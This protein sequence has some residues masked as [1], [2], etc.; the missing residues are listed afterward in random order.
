[1]N[2]S[3][4]REG[5]VWRCQVFLDDDSLEGT[6]LNLFS[7]VNAPVDPLNVEDCH[8]LK[9]TNNAPQKVIVKLLKRK[10]VYLALNVKRSL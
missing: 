8:R 4:I 1:M 10:D 3:S 6:L 5:R 7:K 9:S 2:M